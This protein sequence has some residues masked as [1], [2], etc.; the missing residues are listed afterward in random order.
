MLKALRFSGWPLLAGV[1]V[2]LLII[3]RYPEW[4]GLPS[5]DVNLQWIWPAL[6]IG[7]GVAGLV[8]SRPREPR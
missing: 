1:L 5:L 7:L 4:V 2:A 8:R 6:L 3:Q